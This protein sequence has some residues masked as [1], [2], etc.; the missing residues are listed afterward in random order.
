LLKTPAPVFI[1]DAT[2]EEEACAFAKVHVLLDRS[3]SEPTICGLRKAGGGSL[4][5]SLLQD[6]ISFVLN[7][8]ASDFSYSTAE[9]PHHLLQETFAMQQ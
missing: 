5:F 2:R 7:A 4:P 9:N 6:L 1:L 3:A 8:A